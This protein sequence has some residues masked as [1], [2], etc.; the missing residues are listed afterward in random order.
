MPLHSSIHKENQPFQIPPL[1]AI[2][3][4]HWK[5]SVMLKMHQIYFDPRLSLNSLGGTHDTPRLMMVSVY[6]SG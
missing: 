1:L 2:L 6:R 5:C 3:S 4:Y